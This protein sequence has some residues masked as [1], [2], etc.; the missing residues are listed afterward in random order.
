MDRCNDALQPRCSGVCAYDGSGDRLESRAASCRLRGSRAKDDGL[1]LFPA[2]NGNILSP[3]VAALKVV[4]LARCGLRLGWRLHQ[5]RIA[6]S[7]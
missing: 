3:H 2:G 7:L 5:T 6:E 1:A 4:V